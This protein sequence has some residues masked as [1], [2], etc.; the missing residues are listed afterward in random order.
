MMPNT[1]TGTDYDPD[2]EYS[3]R[4]AAK[5]R[6]TVCSPERQSLSGPRGQRPWF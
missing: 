4:S 1:D 2:P 3:S 6:I 5:L